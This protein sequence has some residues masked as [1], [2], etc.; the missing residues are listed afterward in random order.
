MHNTVHGRKRQRP[1]K[2]KEMTT[3]IAGLKA[4]IQNNTAATEKVAQDTNTNGGTQ[5]AL[6]MLIDTMSPEQ[7]RDFFLKM[8]GSDPSIVNG[9]AGLVAS[10]PVASAPAPSAPVASAPAPSAPAPSAPAP[11]APAP[12]APVASAPAPSAPVAPAP[13]F[14]APVASA[15]AFAAPVAPAPSAPTRRIVA[16]NPVVQSHP[17]AAPATA[18][19]G[20][21]PF[22]MEKKAAAFGMGRKGTRM[23]YNADPQTQFQ[24]EIANSVTAN[25]DFAI[26]MAALVVDCAAQSNS[27]AQPIIPRSLW[28]GLDEHGNPTSPLPPYGIK[29]FSKGANGTTLAKLRQRVKFD[30]NS[31]QWFDTIA[32]SRDRQESI[33]NLKEAVLRNLMWIEH[34]FT[35]YEPV[36]RYYAGDSFYALRGEP[37]YYH[38]NEI[39]G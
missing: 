27:G 13:A 19:S 36:Y 28:S 16:S 25:D 39:F 22:A 37:F 5:S 17:F 7:K 31:N 35:E 18:T 30:Q 1:Q 21:H 10:A 4:Q 33:H 26:R 34:V 2:E 38:T 15:P 24:A 20:H 14:A 23:R 3:K 32:D 29:K 12:S 11:S 8:L 9:L 6:Q